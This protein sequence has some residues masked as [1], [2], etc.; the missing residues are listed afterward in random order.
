MGDPE[1]VGDLDRV[2]EFALDILILLSQTSTRE[3][4]Q[5]G[6][7][8]ILWKVAW[9]ISWEVVRDISQKNW[10]LKEGYTPVALAMLSNASVAD[11]IKARP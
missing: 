8:D 10:L 9:D 7:I 4:K 6:N 3:V 1:E 5:A 2:R 11:V